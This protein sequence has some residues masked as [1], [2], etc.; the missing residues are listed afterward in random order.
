MNFTFLAI[1]HELNAEVHKILVIEVTYQPGFFVI[2]PRRM[3]D[4]RL[5][6]ERA[7]AVGHRPEQG[8]FQAVS[9]PYRPHEQFFPLPIDSPMICNFAKPK[10]PVAGRTRKVLF[11]QHPLAGWF[12]GLHRRSAN[13]EQEEENDSKESHRRN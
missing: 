9:R 11:E 13:T 2:R 7:I 4:M 12:G 1:T 10:P 8:V 3:L 5:D 6:G